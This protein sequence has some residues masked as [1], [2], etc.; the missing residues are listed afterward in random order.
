MTPY[1]IIEF[2]RT[3]A[4]TNDKRDILRENKD[5]ELFQKVLIYAFDPRITFGIKKIPEYVTVLD[6]GVKFDTVFNI[7]DVLAKREVTGNDAIKLLKDILELCDV[8]TAKTIEWIIASDFKAGFGV[9]LVNDEMKPFQVYEVPY[10]GAVS[11]SEKRLNQ[12]FDKH[13]WA[14]SEVKYDGRYLNTILENDSIF[15]ESRGGKPNPL[16]GALEE[17]AKTF[18]EA[19]GYDGVINGELMLKG[20][21]DRYKSNGIIA[22][23]ISIGQKKYDGKDIT[24]ETAKFSKE[25]QV[26]LQE[27]KELITLV[28]W[29]YVP[30]E[31]YRNKTG[32]SARSTRIV[33][34][35]EIIKKANVFQMVEYKIV[36]NASEALQHFL[37]MLKR[38]E[39]GTILKGANGIWS[40]GK[41][42][43]QMKMKLEINLDLVVT[44]FNMGTVGTKNEGLVSSFKA[45][46]ECGLL[47]TNPQGIKEKDMLYITENQDVLLGK[48]IEVKCSGLSTDSDG[49]YSLMYPAY[50]RVRDDKEHGDTLDKAIEIEQMALG[51]KELNE[52]V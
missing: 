44:G 49:N 26:T 33:E 7:L 27:V 10:M 40:D 32:E 12:I 28:V 34:L 51:L 52:A 31:D 2:L 46:T 29:D 38:G 50:L 11:Y 30:I 48:L 41:P 24:K 19:A 42:T 43:H 13:P 20:V 3:T 6:E 45:E 15:T 8:S 22:S 25:H 23:Y 17:E 16:M 21:A 35:E 18:R 47:K 4:G 37:E 14:Y 1:E 5:N 36:N 9:S 39:E